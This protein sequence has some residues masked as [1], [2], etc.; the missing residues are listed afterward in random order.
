MSHLVDLFSSAAHS[1]YSALNSE[2]ATIA[3]TVLSYLLAFRIF[4]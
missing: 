4:A 3:I 1:V 2:V